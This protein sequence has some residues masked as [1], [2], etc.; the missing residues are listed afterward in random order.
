MGQEESGEDGGG[1]DGG[2]EERMGEEESAVPAA[3]SR[4]ALQSLLEYHDCF[5]L[6]AERE[7]ASLAL[8]GQQARA[9]LP[10]PT[11]EGPRGV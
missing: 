4:A 3:A 11:Q 1:E 7:R 2:G 6:E 10:S 9:L 8:L 5:C